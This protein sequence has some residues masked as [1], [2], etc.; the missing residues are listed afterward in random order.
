MLDIPHKLL[1]LEGRPPR[2]LPLQAPDP[3]DALTVPEEQLDSAT[4]D[5]PTTDEHQGDK[6]CAPQET[7]RP[8][9]SQWG[10][11]NLIWRWV[12]A[13]DLAHHHALTVAITPGPYGTVRSG[14]LLR[15]LLP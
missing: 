3:L 1:Y 2:H 10:L 7:A 15:S 5:Q 8:A 6:E 11:I 4:G 12:C 14:Y 9:A 13:L